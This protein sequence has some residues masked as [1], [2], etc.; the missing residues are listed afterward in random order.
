MLNGNY[1]LKKEYPGHKPGEYLF[2]QNGE[3]TW[4]IGEQIQIPQNQI[5][6]R[7]FFEPIV[8]GWQTGQDCWFVSLN[9]M[10]LKDVYSNELHLSLARF[11]NLFKSE[12]E[13]LE[14]QKKV[15]ELFQRLSNKQTKIKTKTKN[16]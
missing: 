5:Q 15:A 2:W 7:E 14:A 16:K 1:I 12:E 13:A 10:V 4:E 6:N 9:G 3:T 11:K 8:L